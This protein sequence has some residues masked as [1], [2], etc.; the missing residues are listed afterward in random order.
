MSE[1]VFPK[2]VMSIHAAGLNSRDSSSH[3]A[4]INESKFRPM[5][6]TSLIAPKTSPS[7]PL[8]RTVAIFPPRLPIVHR[9]TSASSTSSNPP[10]STPGPLLLAC[11]A[12]SKSDSDTLSDLIDSGVVSVSTRAPNGSSL[13]HL[14]VA[15]VFRVGTMKKD[16]ESWWSPPTSP[17]SS[18][19]A[20]AYRTISSSTGPTA[21]IDTMYDDDEFDD[22]DDLLMSFAGAGGILCSGGGIV[23]DSLYDGDGDDDDD[24]EDNDVYADVLNSPG[25]GTDSRGGKGASSS[26]TLHPSSDWRA[27]ISMPGLIQ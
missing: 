24:D 2:T 18:P 21:V 5:L 9:N 4:W 3:T 7:L 26:S 10:K 16:D 14:A 23:D 12:A 1:N 17:L 13:L 15:S 22:D 25:G 6:L 8:S 20:T 27:F 19:T 11:S